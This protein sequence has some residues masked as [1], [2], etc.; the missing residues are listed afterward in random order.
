MI[1][2]A[3]DDITE[4]GFKN[5][6]ANIYTIMIDVVPDDDDYRRCIFATL[7]LCAMGLIHFNDENIEEMNEEMSM[8]NALFGH[9]LIK[10]DSTESGEMFELIIRMENSNE[11]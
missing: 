2:E 10:D 4:N 5:F 8:F 7:R 11:D 1:N 9:T 3:F 6:F